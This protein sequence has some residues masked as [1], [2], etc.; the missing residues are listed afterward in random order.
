[1]ALLSKPGKGAGAIT[2]S[3]RTQ[4]CASMS[5]SSSG[6]SGCTTERISAT[7]SL[8]DFTAGSAATRGASPATGAPGPRTPGGVRTPP[9]EPAQHRG[10]ES[11]PIRAQPDH[12]LEVVEP[13][14]GVVAAAAEDH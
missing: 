13:V 6:E 3:L 12:R 9:G 8:T 14:A 5:P 10:P 4:P 1:M 7:C 11:P 2:S